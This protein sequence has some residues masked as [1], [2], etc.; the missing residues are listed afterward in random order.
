MVSFEAEYFHEIKSNLS[1]VSPIIKKY[2]VKIW[3]QQELRK[4]NKF[5][6]Y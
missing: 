2:K 5:F 6:L 4:I 3:P 1:S